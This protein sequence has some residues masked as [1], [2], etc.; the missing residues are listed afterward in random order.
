MSV[1]PRRMGR[2]QKPKEGKAQYL[3]L[4]GTDSRTQGFTNLSI[5]SFK[6]LESMT[7][8]YYLSSVSTYGEQ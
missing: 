8:K 7:A 2:L 5:I 3:S 6:Y 1:K 4:K